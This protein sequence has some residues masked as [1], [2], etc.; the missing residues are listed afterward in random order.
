MF[1]VNGMSTGGGGYANFSDD[2][3][4][5]FSEHINS[6]LRGVRHFKLLTLADRENNGA[7]ENLSFW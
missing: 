5:A 7:G 4:I 1:N 6:T 2:E 3:K